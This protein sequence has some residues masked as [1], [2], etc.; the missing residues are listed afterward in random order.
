MIWKVKKFLQIRYSITKGQFTQD[1]NPVME[2]LELPG[3]AHRAGVF[4]KIF[5][6]LQKNIY[7]FLKDQPSSIKYFWISEEAIVKYDESV[8]TNVPAVKGTLKIPSSDL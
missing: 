6:G 5:N 4:Y 3:I 7:N 2:F 1:K 8:P